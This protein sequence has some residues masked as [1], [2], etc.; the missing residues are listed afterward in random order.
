MSAGHQQALHN[1]P[2]FCRTV[3]L[4]LYR[5]HL[6]Y[7]ERPHD[8]SPF[9]KQSLSRILEALARLN[10]DRPEYLGRHK[11]CLQG[12]DMYNFAHGEI[13]KIGGLNLDESWYPDHSQP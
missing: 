8:R 13:G 7:L 3:Q 5:K 11:M 12:N 4:G 2:D 9:R 6:P 1:D 10:V